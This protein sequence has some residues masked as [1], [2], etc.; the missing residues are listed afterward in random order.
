M[1]ALAQSFINEDLDPS[2]RLIIGRA[3]AQ[4]AGGSARAF[5]LKMLQRPSLDVRI[6]AIR[7]L[8]WCRNPQDMRI[9]G[10]ALR[11]QNPDVRSAAV[12]S[13]RDTGTPGAATFLGKSL[14]QVDEALMLVIAE[15][16]SELPD[17]PQVLIDATDHPDLLVRRAV[18]QGLGNIDQEWAEEKL[19]DM[20][21]RDPEWLVRSAAESAVEAKEDQ[22]RQETTIPVPPKIDEIDWLITWAAEQGMGLGLGEAAIETLVMAAQE[23]RD[24]VQVL[25]ALTLTR[26][27]RESHI[28]ILESMVE[29]N[30][31]ESVRA[32]A[33]YGLHELR[34]RYPDTLSDTEGQ[35]QPPGT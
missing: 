24:D 17:G 15:A 30:A 5:F 6:A 23:G 14:D 27:G 10:A 11:D 12:R 28:P 33:L 9:L 4:V 7:G 8:G 18:A 3:L 25:S 2:D 19:I 1:K 13:L 16:L 31:S 26:I 34:R 20:M 29:G 35:Q 22:E 21:K 32:A